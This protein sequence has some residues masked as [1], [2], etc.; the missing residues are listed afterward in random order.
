MTAR[1]DSA[2]F[3][4]PS[5]RVIVESD[6]VVRWVD[7]S[8]RKHYDAFY[9]SPISRRLRE[10]GWL[11]EARE[12]EPPEG[13]Y[14]ALESE[15][16]P[17]VSY[18][19]EWSF[20]QWREAALLTLDMQLDLLEHDFVLKDATPFNVQ[21][22]GS[23]PVFIDL[24]SFEVL[25][26]GAPWVAYRQFCETFL[27]PLLLMAS[28]DPGLGSLLRV[29]LDGVPLSLCS[30]LLPLRVKLRPLTFVHVVLHGKLGS[31]QPAPSA[32]GSPSRPIG[33]A[34]LQSIAR[35]LRSVVARLEPRG[36]DSLWSSY[37]EAHL[38]YTEE[39]FVHKKKVLEGVLDSARPEVVWD[40]GCNTGVFSEICADR[41]AYVVAFDSDPLC[42]EALYTSLRR[43]GAE[44]ILPLILDLANP[45]AGLGWA[46][47]ERKPV[48]ERGRADLTLALGL[49]HHLRFSHN[50]PFELQA[51]LFSRCGDR[52]LVE[53]V[54]AEDEMT[55]KLSH[56]KPALLEGYTEE[57]FV[58]AFGAYFDVEERVRL[59]G[60]TRT[61]FLLRGC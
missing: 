1:Q 57:R 45:S 24:L 32:D 44:M 26:K 7:A 37:Y 34:S 56:R 49:V 11:L 33:K 40:L 5:G 10:K 20:S 3:R 19:Y 13:V 36:A 41:G 12:I 14:K 35:Q 61:L 21:F 22:C 28:V 58:E 17:F 29:Y 60:S 59:T 38:N 8:Y 4:D 55:R 31:S 52:L 18:P 23:R 48:L 39:A 53:F 27:A 16:I 30:K 54:P 43:D 15:K 2:S 6:R 46:N 47:R 42:I 25:E 9:E 50:V 51:E